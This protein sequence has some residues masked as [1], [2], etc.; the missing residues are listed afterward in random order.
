MLIGYRRVRICVL[1]ESFIRRL[2]AEAAVWAMVV[3]VVLPFSKFVVEDLGAVDDE[4]VEQGRRTLQRR[5][6]VGSLQL[7]LRR[8]VRGLM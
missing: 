4:P 6:A 3:V 2:T 8:G 7:P 1:S 5:W